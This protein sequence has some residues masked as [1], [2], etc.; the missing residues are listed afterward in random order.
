M[1]LQPDGDFAT[2]TW[3]PGDALHRD[4]STDLRGAGGRVRWSRDLARRGVRPTP[5]WAP[6]RAGGSDRA[7]VPVARL[8]RPSGSD[9]LSVW[10]AGLDRPAGCQR[11]AEGCGDQRDEDGD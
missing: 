6:R 7:D 4:R 10:R 11:I 2:R 8:D 3:L 1:R 5:R 9:L